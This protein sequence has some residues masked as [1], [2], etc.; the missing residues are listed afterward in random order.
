MQDA[1]V[2]RL[3]RRGGLVNYMPRRP[4]CYIAQSC[5]SMMIYCRYQN[6]AAPHKKCLTALVPTLRIRLVQCT[7]AAKESLARGSSS[8]TAIS[9]RQPT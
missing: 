7:M 8:V 4:P 3:V 2:T 9:Y 5:D 6:Y 1:R